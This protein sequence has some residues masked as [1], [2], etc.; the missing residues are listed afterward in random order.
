VGGK[1]YR[2]KHK[3]ERINEIKQWKGQAYLY[4]AKEDIDIARGQKGQQ[5]PPPKMPPN[6]F[7]TKN[8]PNFYIFLLGTLLGRLSSGHSG[9]QCRLPKE[10]CPL[11][12]KFLVTPKK[13]DGRGPGNIA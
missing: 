1:R 8:A 13:E 10:Q 6:T 3:R 4:V 12:D 2:G 5:P 7:L 9:G 11:Q